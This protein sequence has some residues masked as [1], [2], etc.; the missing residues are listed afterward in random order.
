MPRFHFNVIGST[1]DRD[2]EGTEFLDIK[3][4]KRKARRYA[5]TRLSDSVLM[6]DP[7]DDWR[8]EITDPTGLILFR[9]DVT[10]TDSPAT[11]R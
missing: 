4:A 8:I 3:A 9:I 7:D 5:G 11:S 1:A 10:V 2:L 6:S